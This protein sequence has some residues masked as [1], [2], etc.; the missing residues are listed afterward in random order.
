MKWLNRNNIITA[1][2]LILAGVSI[3]THFRQDDQIKQLL[4]Q[5]NHDLE[6]QMEETALELRR[7]EDSRN[8]YRRLSDSLTSASLAL[9]KQLQVKDKEIVAIK[10][11]YNNIPVDSLSK[12]MEYRAKWKRGN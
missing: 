10:G 8:Y 9:R 2:L 5:Q 12:L 6:Q 7:S 3:A 11:R 4:R 1:V